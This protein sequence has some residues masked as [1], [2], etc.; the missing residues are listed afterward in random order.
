MLFRY[1]GK[2]HT[3]LNNRTLAKQSKKN[4]VTHLRRTVY[5]SYIKDLYEEL[6]LYLKSLVRQGALISKDKNSAY[7]L[8]GEH[9]FKLSARNILQFD[10]LE[11]LIMQI[12]NDIIRKLDNERSTLFLI[13]QVCTKLGLKVS[14]STIKAA[15][16]FLN[17]RHIL[18]HADGHMDKDFCN[19]NPTFKQD[20]KGRILYPNTP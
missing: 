2:K 11:N 9:N 8:L 13:N 15:L 4:V 5:S 19:L 18:V 14:D 17:I 20:A 7:R 1:M 16:P 12:A 10:T 6:T 3:K